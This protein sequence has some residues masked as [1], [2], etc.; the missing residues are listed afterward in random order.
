MDDEAEIPRAHEYYMQLPP[1][2]PTTSRFMGSEL[3][4]RYKADPGQWVMDGEL[5]PEEIEIREILAASI[6]LSGQIR[7]RDWLFRGTGRLAKVRELNQRL[8]SLA[9]A[10]E[11]YRAAFSRIANSESVSH[12]IRDRLKS[13]LD[14]SSSVAA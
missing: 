8:M 13:L 12:V 14:K 5:P 7:L 3:D 6:F 11:S 4:I 10:N 2:N 1:F 9:H